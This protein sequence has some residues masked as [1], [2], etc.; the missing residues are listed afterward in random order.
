[1]RTIGI[2]EDVKGKKPKDGEEKTKSGSEKPTPQ[3]KESGGNGVKP[4]IVEE[5][6]DAAVEQSEGV[7]ATGNVEKPEGAD[8]E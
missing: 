5:K 4:E 1:M 7:G 2:I 8:K 3:K 6:T